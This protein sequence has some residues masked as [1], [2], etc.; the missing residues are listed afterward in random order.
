MATPTSLPA[1][2]TAGDVLTA[3]NMNLLRGAFRILQVVEGSTTTGV[4]SSTNTFVDT[5]LTATITP[6][7]TSSKVLVIAHQNGLQKTNANANNKMD[8]RL[9][10]G[11]TTLTTFAAAALFTGTAIE[12]I[13]PSAVV[14][15]LDSPATTSATTYKTQFNNSNN[16]AA[17]NVQY[18]SDRSTM[19]LLEVSA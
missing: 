16:T 6:T 15:Y 19:L 18:Q 3:A 4:T 12:L 2:F 11:V 13:V 8:L 10:R 14:Y 5:N 17:V 9:V 7:S 1:S